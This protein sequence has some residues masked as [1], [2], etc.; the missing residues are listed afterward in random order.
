MKNVILQFWGKYTQ[1]YEDNYLTPDSKN[2]ADLPSLRDKLFISILLLTVPICLLTYIPS[3]II[4][5]KTH[6]LM[7]GIFNTLGLACLLLIFLDK[8]IRIATKKTVFLSIF[9]ILAVILLIFI[10]SKG[11]G[12]I[13]LICISVLTT[14]FQSRK[15]GIIA[16]SLNAVIILFSLMFFPIKGMSLSFLQDSNYDAW[17]AVS[18][19]MIAFNFLLILSVSFTV[20]QLNEWFL[21]EKGVQLLL[22]A[23]SINLLKAKE[24]AEESDRLKTAFLNNISHEIRTPLNGILGFAPEIIR[25]GI[26]QQEKE[27]Y[28]KHL[29]LSADRLMNT[30]NNYMD[31]SLIV[32]GNMRVNPRVVG[33]FSMMQDLQQEFQNACTEKSLSFKIVHSVAGEEVPFITDESLLRKILTHLLD[34]AVKFTGSGCI[35]LGVELINHKLVFFVKDRGEGISEAA[36]KYVLEAFMQENA[37]NTRAYEGSGLGLAISSG[38][39]KLLGGSIK[40]ESEKN[41]GTTVY[42]S[43]P[44]KPDV[45]A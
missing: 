21:K 31:M 41:S 6:Q 28:L 33:Y 37:S 43:L 5:V 4:T 16:A 20:D 9:Y 23:E 32:S 2:E 15:A 26:L 11:P 14:L 12:I 22:K 42:V 13:I 10:G 40:I 19:N 27:L 17:I 45:S 7:I 34:N 25:P 44:V 18:I 30:I 24:R 3:I 8:T 1:Y 29:N 36:Q 39:I 35:S 38:L